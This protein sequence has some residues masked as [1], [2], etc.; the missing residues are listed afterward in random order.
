MIALFELLKE[1]LKYTDSG[2][3]IWLHQGTRTDLIGKIAG[4]KSSTD[5]YV[6]IKFMQ[7]RLSAHRF[8]FYIHHGYLPKEIDHIN[9]VRHDNKIGNLRACEHTH[10]LGNQ[11]IQSRH[12]SSKY[13]G[14]CWDKNRG[15][16]IASIKIN[17]KSKYLGRYA[18]EED[19]AMAYNRAALLVF[20]VFANLNE[21][22]VN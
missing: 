5:G 7:K 2:D 12:K 8:I 17:S 19:A 22:T 13:K 21:T 15:K 4:N 14:V 20:G 11:S 1:R 9:R 6:Y 10:N 3:L 18:R 16:W